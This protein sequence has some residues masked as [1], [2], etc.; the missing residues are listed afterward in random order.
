MDKDPQVI[1]TLI[2]CWDHSPRSNRGG[3]ILHNST[4][5]LFQKHIKQIF[6]IVKHKSEQNQF[7]FLKSWNEWAEGNYME[8]D[9]KWGKQYIKVLKKEIEYFQLPK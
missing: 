9:L 2:P 4:P 6:N 1:P 8:P 5:E 3:L 7:I